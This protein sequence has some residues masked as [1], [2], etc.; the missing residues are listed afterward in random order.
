MRRYSSDSRG[1]HIL[2]HFLPGSFCRPEFFLRPSLRSREGEEDLSSTTSSSSECIPRARSMFPTLGR[3]IVVLRAD[4]CRIAL[5][6]TFGTPS[7]SCFPWDPCNT[8]SCQEFYHKSQLT[9]SDRT[10]KLHQPTCPGLTSR[11]TFGLQG[12]DESSESSSSIRV[13]SL[14]FGEIPRVLT[15]STGK[16]ISKSSI[17]CSVSSSGPIDPRGD[18]NIWNVT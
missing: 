9:M 14:L 7:V 15:D 1:T 13:S 11:V 6:L 3:A 5:L 18:S 4:C 2:L 10:L 8:L 17:S 16:L 12:V